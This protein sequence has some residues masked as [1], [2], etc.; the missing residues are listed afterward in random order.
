MCPAS[1]RL[2]E[3]AASTLCAGCRP[4]ALHTLQNAVFCAFPAFPCFPCFSTD[5]G[6][7]SLPSGSLLAE[8]P[9]VARTTT[10]RLFDP[11]WPL[12]IL[13]IPGQKPYSWP[14]ELARTFR[15]WPWPDSRPAYCSKARKWRFRTFLIFLKEMSEKREAARKIRPVYCSNVFQ[16][17]TFPDVFSRVFRVFSCFLRTEPRT[18]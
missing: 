6:G 15:F 4:I 7:P 2:L 10:L 3:G 5:S 14:P 9:K 8:W 16:M 1:E 11:G 17:D 18:L 12:A 13:A